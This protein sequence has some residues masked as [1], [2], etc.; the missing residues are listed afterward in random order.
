MR[1]GNGIKNINFKTFML[2]GDMGVFLATIIFV[3]ILSISSDKFFTTDNFYAISRAFSLW[4]IVGLAQMAALVVGN[5]NLSV[6]AIGGLAAM[7]TGFL[8]NTYESPIWLAVLAGLAVGILCGALNGIII[9]KTGINAFIV[10]LGMASVF[11]G[12]LFGFTHSLSYPNIPDSFKFVVSGKIFGIIPMV[13]L[14]MLVISILLWLMFSYTVI[15][16][17]ILAVGGNA[18]TAI[19]SGI[20][21]ANITLFVH[22]LSGF[23]AAVAGV[24][25]VA[26]LGSAHTSIGTNWL[27]LSFA[28]PIIG[29]TSLAGGATSIFGVVLGGI[30]LTV[31]RNGLVL[32]RVD[33]FWEQFFIGL[34][35]L[36][37]VGIDRIRTVYTLRKY[38]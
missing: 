6:G 29:G 11:T 10:T 4:I 28:I 30:L 2:R 15:G 1:N 21:V 17:R 27:L 31:I 26:R 8:F 34:L 24:L 12:I 16:R 19:L 18:E 13:F 20:S 37:A 32:I 35:V 25:F 3:V 9:T 36:I 5:M 38:S 7:A 22:V 14:I 33:P 23:L